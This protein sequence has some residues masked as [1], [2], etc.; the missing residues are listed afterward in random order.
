MLN[1]TFSYSDIVLV[2]FLAG[3][4]ILLSA[5]NALAIAYL[6]SKLERHKRTK[7][8]WI[9]LLSGI[10]IRGV[11]IFFVAFLIKFTFIQVIGAIY[12]IYIGSSFFFIKKKKNL[13]PVFPSFWKTV[14]II[15]VTDTIFAVDSILAAFAIV[16]I[17]M[18]AS[19]LPPK[20]WIIYLGAIIGILFMRVAAKIALYLMDKFQKLHL[21][22]H[23][24][25]VWIGLKMLFQVFDKQF[26]LSSPVAMS[27][28]IVF[29]IGCIGI[30]S[31]ATWK[32]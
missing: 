10:L 11:T 22:S 4:E 31:Y 28:S 26:S 23:L 21:A 15:E 7:A 5:D 20:I 18:P 1:Q 25:I 13:Y 32:D 17:S 24:L 3:V 19:G 27:A 29:W 6:A 8:L 12:L 14:C 16:G 2:L 30:I 9:G